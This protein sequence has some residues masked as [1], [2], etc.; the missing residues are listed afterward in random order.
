MTH[1]SPS[2]ASIALPHW[3]ALGA[4]MALSSCASYTTDRP[5]KLV[6]VPSDWQPLPYHVAVIPFDASKVK[7]L[8]DGSDRSGAAFEFEFKPLAADSEE[9]RGDFDLLTER[10]QG[11]LGTNAFRKVTVLPRPSAFEYEALFAAGLLP[12]YWVA[13]ARE[14]EADLLLDID[15]FSYPVKPRSRAELLSFALFLAGPVE[16]LFPDREYYFDGVNLE[17]SLYDIE[18][19]DAPRYRDR[20]HLLGTVALASSDGDD[21]SVANDALATASDFQFEPIQ[22][23][24]IQGTLRQF[25]VSPPSMKFRFGDR[26]GGGPG[27]LSF[28]TSIFIP[29]AWL[30]RGSSAFSERLTDDTAIALAQDLAREIV[31]GDYAYIVG[32]ARSATGLL[33]DA[34]TASLEAS[35]SME[36]VLELKARIRRPAT[37]FDRPQVRV[38]GRTYSIAFQP[39]VLTPNTSLRTQVFER[40]S[41]DTVMASM[42]PATDSSEGF[43]QEMTLYLPSPKEVGVFSASFSELS[44]LVPLDSVQLSLGEDLGSRGFR[45]KSWTFDLAAVYSEDDLEA[46]QIDPVLSSSSTISAPVKGQ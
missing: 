4:V 2:T 17:A 25:I 43:D 23:G 10:L 6:N 27:K 40:A 13:A 46:L 36:G 21:G 8:A 15:S 41:A 29:S 11:V 19:L 30:Q 44:P 20:Q 22:G 1:R 32:P 42:T 7:A 37:A 3:L 16:L 5:E 38:M 28:W 26:L 14:A 31:E 34:K 24:A 35:P 12:S 9:D 39:G 33:F 45:E 18:G